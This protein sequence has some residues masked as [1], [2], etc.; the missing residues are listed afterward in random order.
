MRTASSQN[1]KFC[2]KWVGI[3]RKIF[4]SGEDGLGFLIKAGNGCCLTSAPGAAGYLRIASAM[5][6]PR[7]WGSVSWIARYYTPSRLHVFV[8]DILD[9]DEI[10][11]YPVLIR[12]VRWAKSH[13][14]MRGFAI[15]L[16][17]SSREWDCKTCDHFPILMLPPLIHNVETN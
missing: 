14:Q 2:N 10:S 12:Q 13:I 8:F 11:K 1:I 5:L 16:G 17:G 7:R 3:H 4:K 6:L 15:L 9:Y